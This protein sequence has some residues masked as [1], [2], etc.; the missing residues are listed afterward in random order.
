MQ[1]EL[2]GFPAGSVVENPPANTGEA[3]SIPGKIIWKRRWQLTPVFLPGRSHGSLRSLE[4]YSPEGCKRV[5]HDLV[6]EQQQVELCCGYVCFE[7]AN[8]SPS[9]SYD[10]V[11]VLDFFFKILISCQG[12]IMDHP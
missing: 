3:D 8:K 2:W 7:K 4:G 5:G 9:I 6:T 12:E 1:F 11:V 10:F